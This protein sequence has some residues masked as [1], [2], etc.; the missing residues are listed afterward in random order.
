MA[1][2][3]AKSM[4]GSLGCGAIGASLPILWLGLISSK[5]EDR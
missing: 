5:K 2:R 3:L 1:T 4:M